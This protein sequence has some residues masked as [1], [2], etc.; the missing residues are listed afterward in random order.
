MYDKTV[1]RRRAVLALLVALSLILLTAY[2]G[3]SGGGGLHSVQRGFV[4]VVSPIQAGASKALKPVRDLFNWFGDTLHAKGQVSELRKQND[5]LRQELITN[6]SDARQL[7]EF[8]KLF[9]IDGE[10]KLTDYAPVTARVIGRDPTLWYS[11]DIIDKGSS[12]GIHMD[13]PV[14][15]G[16]GLVGKVTLVTPGASQ[17]TLITD[18]TSGVS[19]MVN[20]SG[21][22]GVVQPAVGNPEDLVLQYLQHGDGVSQG[23]DVVTSGTVS[24]RLDSLFPPGIPIGQVTSVSSADLY[25]SVHVRPFATLNRL[26]YVQVLTRGTQGVHPGQVAQ[27]VAGLPPPGS[28]PAGGG[29]GGQGASGQAVASSGSPGGGP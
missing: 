3:E 23:D 29:G 5:Q 13:A 14:V 19:A 9:K 26:D 7:S 11:T 8:E 24:G 25:K 1:R 6:Q 2:F 28:G 15:N 20:K 22:T 4:E 16:E 27:A 10:L 17:V 18:H 12:D 21:A